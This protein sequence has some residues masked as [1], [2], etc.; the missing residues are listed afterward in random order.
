MS[1]AG[2]RKEEV[3]TFKVDED[4]AEALAGM[5]NRSDFIR[6]AVLAALGNACPVCSGTGI[7]SVSQK[8]HWDAF[9]EYHHVQL[10]DDCHET[11]LVCDHETVPH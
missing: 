9:A 6:Q 2:R 4:L 7:L 11:H 1:A 10:C 3:I 5:R 8:R